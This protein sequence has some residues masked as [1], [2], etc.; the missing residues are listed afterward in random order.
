MKGLQAMASLG[1][2]LILYGQR[3]ESNLYIFKG[4]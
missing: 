1:K 4:S 2:H 3:A